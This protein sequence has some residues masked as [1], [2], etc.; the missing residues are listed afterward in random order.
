MNKYFHVPG[1]LLGFVFKKDDKTKQV[2]KARYVGAQASQFNTYVTLKLQNVKST[3]VTVKGASPCWEQDFLFE[4]NDLNTGLLIEVWSKGMIWDRAMGYH[5]IPLQGVQYSNEEGNG[6]WLSL[7]AELVMRDGE[8][9]GTKNPTGHSLLVDC[10]FELPFGRCEP[11]SGWRTILKGSTLCSR[12]HPSP[13]PYASLDPENIGASELQRKLEML[14]HI[15]DQEARAEQ[16]RRQMQY[17]GHSG[18]SEDSDY[19]SDLNYPVGQHANSSASQ[20]R[21]AAHQINTPQRSLET[22]RENSYEKDEVVG[23]HL[24]QPMALQHHLS[25]GS[26]R[27]RHLQQRNSPNTDYGYGSP[28]VSQNMRQYDNDVD[29][30]L[31]YNSRP[32]NKPE[33]PGSRRRKYTWDDDSQDVWDNYENYNNYNQKNLGSIDGEYPFEYTYYDEV[34]TQKAKEIRRPSLERQITLYD[35]TNYFPESY[36]PYTSKNIPQVTCVT[37]SGQSYN[38]NRSYDEYDT[39]SYAYQDERYGQDEEDRQ[40]DSG[41][42]FYNNKPNGKKLPAIPIVQKRRPSYNSIQDETTYYNNCTSTPTARRKMPQIPTRR[43][44]SRQSSINDET[45]YR[46]PENSSHRGA[47]LPATPTKTSK[48]LARLN[49]HAKP[50]NSLPPTPGRQLPN[51]NHLS[52]H[53]SAKFRRNHLMKRTSSADYSDQDSYDN[54]Y[55]RSGTMSARDMY[56]DYYNPSYQSSTSL[57]LQEE[58]RD[59][60]MTVLVCD[61]TVNSNNA[62]CNTNSYHQQIQYSTPKDN[63]YNA[64]FDNDSDNRR[65]KILGQRDSNIYYQQNTDSLESRD[66]DIKDSFETALSSRESSTVLQ[67]QQNQQIQNH[68]RVDAIPSVVNTI[69]HQNNEHYSN[70][71][72]TANSAQVQYA[73]QRD[74]MTVDTSKEA[75]LPSTKLTPPSVVLNNNT[76]VNNNRK[77]VLKQ[78]TID[79]IYYPA[80]GEVDYFNDTVEMEYPDKIIEEDPYL[81]PQESLESFTEEGTVTNSGSIDYNNKAITRG[82]PVSVI[83]VEAYEDD[84]PEITRGS[85]QITVVDPYNA[86]SSRRASLEPYRTVSPHRSERYSYNDSVMEDDYGSALPISRKNS[87][88]DLCQGSV[89]RRASVRHSPVILVQEP[90]DLVPMV[91][92]TEQ[93]TIPFQHEQE[94]KAPRPKITAKQRWLWAYNKIVM[95]LNMSTID[96]KQPQ[97]HKRHAPVSRPLFNPNPIFLLRLPRKLQSTALDTILSKAAYTDPPQSNLLYDTSP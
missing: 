17:L 69:N 66:D 50:F 3:T 28:N 11:P 70:V 48:V 10:R 85:S 21:H 13:K 96:L 58:T 54:Q 80:E 67:P 71:T 92:D 95:Q 42:G 77:G 88:A 7:E 8:V 56:D 38:Q 55:V 46:T 68:R 75:I 97:R 2:K 30:E 62:N 6:Q 81:D 1:K 43:S 14:N 60:T 26:H 31:W 47:S 51:P 61:N 24:Q 15:M 63:Y 4:T 79:S 37:T 16:A 52:Y 25:P 93:K 94:A 23:Q 29:L 18:Y 72:I 27:Q 83:H 44:A 90:L 91:N 12:N 39:S 74:Q 84:E 82:S 73:I 20:Y 87:A 36:T 57:T 41:G 65:K 86:P 5:W 76:I 89:S 45:G 59:S 49:A 34:P 53:R 35:D 22:S 33:Y 78:D 19:T 9:V 64:D 32:R 40:W